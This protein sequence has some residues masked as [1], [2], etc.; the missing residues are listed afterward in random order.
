MTEQPPT[1]FPDPYPDPAPTPAP[2]PV[3]AD[4]PHRTRRLIAGF[5]TTALVAGVGGVGAGYVVGHDSRGSTSNEN[6][7]PLS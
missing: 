6:I 7:I 1:A 5:A 3:S 4:R 2:A